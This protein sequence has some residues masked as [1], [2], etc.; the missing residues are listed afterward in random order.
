[1]KALSGN[2]AQVHIL[3]V[4]IVAG[5]LLVSLYFIRGFDFTPS[6]IVSG[7]N[8]LKQKGL[9]IVTRLENIPDLQGELSNILSRYMYKALKGDNS[10]LNNYISNS[11]PEDIIYEISIVNISKMSKYA[12]SIGDCQTFVYKPVIKIG[13]KTSVSRVVVIDG[14]IYELD[15]GMWF[16]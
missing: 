4:I 3:E 14:Y 16:N 8:S 7:S 15:F 6:S 2:K 1:M 10:S 13:E 9:N 12:E 11:L 5:I